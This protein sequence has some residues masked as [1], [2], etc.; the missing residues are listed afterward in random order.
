M[1]QR[2]QTQTRTGSVITLT[3]VKIETGN[4]CLLDSIP[5]DTAIGYRDCLLLELLYAKGIRRM[6]VIKLKLQDINLDTIVREKWK[7]KL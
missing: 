2:A 7:R 6:E 4:I 3:K 1:H 5:L